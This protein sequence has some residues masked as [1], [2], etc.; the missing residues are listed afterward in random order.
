MQLLRKLT[1]KLSRRSAAHFTYKNVLLL[2]KLAWRRINWGS[3]GLHR[4]RMVNENNKRLHRLKNIVFVSVTLTFDIR[5]Q[6]YWLWMWRKLAL[7]RVIWDTFRANSTVNEINEGPLLKQLRPFR[8]SFGPFSGRC[9]PLNEILATPLWWAFNIFD[10]NRIWGG[11][12][13]WLFQI[14]TFTSFNG[15]CKGCH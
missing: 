7:C 3:L 4:N 12:I 14:M 6:I 5:M 10:K 9:S 15:H 1:Y 13:K 11:Q 2:C 8:E